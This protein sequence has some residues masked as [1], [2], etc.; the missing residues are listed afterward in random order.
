[1]GRRPREL[2]A[3]SLTN[4]SGARTLIDSTPGVLQAW[5]IFAK[6]YGLDAQAVAQATHGRRLYDTIKEYCHVEDEAKLQVPY[7]ASLDGVTLTRNTAGRD[8]AL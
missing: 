1:M 7:M 4:A 2:G 6:D 8:Y 5:A 3:D